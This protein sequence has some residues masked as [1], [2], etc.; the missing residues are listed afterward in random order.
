MRWILGI[1]VGLFG[2]M[3]PWAQAW[4][5]KEH[6][7]LTR[8]A[9]QRLLADPTT[10]PAMK[11]WLEENTPGPTEINGERDYFLNKR[12][13]LIPRD[14]DGLA[15]WATMPDMATF[16][17]SP[18]KKI[19]PYGVHEKLLHYIDV[20]FFM[21]EENQRSY[22]HDLSNKPQLSDFPRDMTDE[23]Y[24]RAGML[25]FRVEECYQ[26]LVE[27]I[28]E[29]RL[30]DRPGQYPRDHHAVKWAGYLA[31]YLQDNTQPHHATVDYKSQSYFPG[32]RAPNIHAEM[33]Y[34]MGDDEFNDPME[35]R[36]EF[37]PMFV[38][39]MDELKDP[40]ETN[41]LWQ[42]TLEISLQSYDALPLIGSAAQAANEAAGG[43][44]TETFMRF[45][46]RYLDQEMSVME[47]K[48]RQMAWAVK[49]VER[50]WRAAWE[51]AGRKGD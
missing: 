40:I 49:R 1:M 25:P 30:A 41:D 39:A 6:I 36:E 7:Q 42:A 51:E 28:R 34:K 18:E 22:R 4:S 33:E 10:P 19:K 12:V 47:M 17:D 35:L 2:I 29:G 24:K 11:R 32:R 9:A 3:P 20:E 26:N 21:P 5:N 8:L 44:N 46:G 14:V 27:A 15:Y 16:T 31:H 37:W 43:F 45:K 13:G 50:V 48:A 23:R 38:A